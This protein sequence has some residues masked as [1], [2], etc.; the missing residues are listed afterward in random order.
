VSVLSLMQRCQGQ[1][2]REPHCALIKIEQ[3]SVVVSIL[4]QQIKINFIC[5]SFLCISSVP[6]C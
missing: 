6:R 2:P 1:T 3:L 4:Y 5:E